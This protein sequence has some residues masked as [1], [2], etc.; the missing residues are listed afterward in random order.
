MHYLYLKKNDKILV[1][2]FFLNSFFL[3]E[4]LIKI[5]KLKWGEA[6]LKLTVT[7]KISEKVEFK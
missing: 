4:L 7:K 3:S 2:I 1:K 6:F 5:K